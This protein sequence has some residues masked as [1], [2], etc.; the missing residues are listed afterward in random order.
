MWELGGASIAACDIPDPIIDTYNLFYELNGQQALP[1]EHTPSVLLADAAPGADHTL[2]LR[3]SMPCVGSHGAGQT[4]SANLT[5]T[6]T[7]P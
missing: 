7:V 6:A 3:L 1:V 2:N 5:L 4:F